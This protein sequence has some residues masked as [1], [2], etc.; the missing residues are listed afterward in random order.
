MP[1]NRANPAWRTKPCRFFAVNGVCIKGSYCRF[2][3]IDEDG[4]DL[5]ETPHLNEIDGESSQEVEDPAG[6]HEGFEEVDLTHVGA[7]EELFYED[8]ESLR[9]PPNFG[10]YPGIGSSYVGT[11]LIKVVF[12]LEPIK[13]KK[14]E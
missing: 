9:L 13:G 14:K 6:T 10:I 2:T 8:D 4:S 1:I 7:M 3:H 5:H 12:S 11:K